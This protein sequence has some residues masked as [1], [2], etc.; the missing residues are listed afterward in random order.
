M[1]ITSIK[2]LL[3]PESLNSSL[4]H[5]MNYFIT[6]F[7]TQG[8]SFISIP[9]FTRLFSLGDYGIV[10]I[11]GTYVSL[12]TL[13]LPLGT[14]SISRYFYDKDKTGTDKKA[15]FGTSVTVS[16]SLLLI[17]FTVMLI[18]RNKVSEWM[19]LPVS[20]LVF[21]IPYIFYNIL[22][23]YFSQ[24]NQT[25][26]LT[27]KIASLQITKSYI[28]FPL[29][30]LFVWLLSKER[31]M[32]MFYTE[33]V[34]ASIFGA[35]IIYYLRSHIKLWHITKEHLIY[36]YKNSIPFI[37]YLL[38]G[39]ILSQFDRVMINSYN[40]SSDA[41]LY[42]F[43]YNISMLQLM[44]SNAVSNGW[45]P[46]YY[47][48][49]NEK[50]YKG[51]D[52]QIRNLFQLISILTCFLIMFSGD[53]G[54]ILASKSYHSALYLIP[55]IIIGNYF[56][57]I[58]QVYGRSFSYYMKGWVASAVILLSGLLNIILNAIY[59][60]KY[61]YQA[62]AY[63]TLISY[64]FLFLET[65]LWS[66]YILKKHTTNPM[67]FKKSF[68]FILVVTSTFYFLNF[69]D[70]KLGLVLMIL[71]KAVVFLIELLLFYYKYITGFLTS[72]KSGN[73]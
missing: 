65:W 49:M 38:S 35:Y 6:A 46:E 34:C 59:I 42:S 36:L 57:G 20:V 25:Q 22:T 21:F 26:G 45:M 5:S 58:Y 53:L 55:V 67:I 12:L 9:I 73:A 18:F 37:P 7:A 39:Q 2:K 27:K 63:T 68:L 52:D 44:V 31:Y 56:L 72:I 13:I 23:S 50:N 61:G 24:Y 16:F 3:I 41:G 48:Q 28:S 4:K 1:Q 51:H 66:K 10:N 15:Y 19:S 43:A 64:F 11:F 54:Q 14:D 47:K 60:P 8:L 29:A 17:S 30:V 71:L 40:G 62:C 69:L 32:G 70:L 33:A